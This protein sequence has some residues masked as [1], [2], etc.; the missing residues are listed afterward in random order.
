MN[1]QRRSDGRA[2]AYQVRDLLKTLREL[3]EIE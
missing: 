3:G 1:F 2:V